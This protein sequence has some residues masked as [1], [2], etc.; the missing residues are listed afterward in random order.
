MN[1]TFFF[2]LSSS[3]EELELASSGCDEE[4]SSSLSVPRFLPF[5]PPFSQKN[6]GFYAF[7]PGQ[8]AFLILL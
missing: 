5:N 1:Q 3:F 4:D 6:Y 8:N 7:S 2:C